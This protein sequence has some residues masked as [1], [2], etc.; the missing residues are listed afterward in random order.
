MNSG[1]FSLGGRLKDATAAAH[2]EIEADLDLMGQ[3]RSRQRVTVLLERFLGFHRVWEAA[4][5]QSA[6]RDFA[7]GR[8]RLSALE[9]DLLALGVDAE[10]LATLPPC[11]PAQGLAA[12]TAGCIGSLYVMEGS[13]LGGQVISRS[14]AETPWAP[15]AGLAYFNPYG[16]QTAAP[17]R[18]FLTWAEQA[19]G[20]QDHAM[21][22]DAA[23]ETFK[24]L[25][26]WLKGASASADIDLAF[27]AFRPPDAVGP[28]L[29][30]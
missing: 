28:R 25:G 22:C 21:I 5:A 27:G 16:R 1:Q 12:S 3:M 18:A 20:G 4:L 13:T 7:A 17:W 11:L 29:T 6:V 15:Q 14:L 2:Q 10:R 26:A 9:S 24:V 23:V 19:A 30:P 8:S